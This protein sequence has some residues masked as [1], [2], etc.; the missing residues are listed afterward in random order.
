MTLRLWLPTP[1]NSGGASAAGAGAAA[2]AISRPTAA[3][4]VRVGRM[5]FPG[6][7]GEGNTRAGGGPGHTTSIDGRGR[8]DRLILPR[9]VTSAIAKPPLSL[10]DLRNPG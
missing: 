3:A 1:S 7:R 8:V 2:A 10:V 5:E 6:T 4:V 9:R